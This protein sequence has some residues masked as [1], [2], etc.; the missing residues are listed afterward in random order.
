MSLKLN[1]QRWLFSTNAK[2]IAVLY[3]IFA[4][5]SAM[6]GT[7]LSAIIRLELANTGSPFLNHNT[8]AFNVVITAHAIL[9]IFFFWMPA[10]VGGFVN[11]LMPLMLGAS[12]M[13]FARLNNISFWLLVPSLIL[14]LTSALVEAGAGTG[15][16]VYFPLAGIQSHSG[17]A[18]DLAIFSLHL[19]GFSSLLGAINFITT[20]I[21][22]RTIGMK[23]ENVP[24]FA[25]AVLFTAILLLLSLPV[26]AA[27]L[28]MGIFDRNFNTSFF[29]YAGGGDAVLYQHLFLIYP[30]IILISIPGFG[31]ISHAVS[32][33]A[34]KPV[35]GVQGMIYAMG[36]I[37][38]LG[39]CVSTHHMFAVGLDSDTRAYF[40][41]A[42]MVIAVPTSIKIFSWLSKPFSKVNYSIK[43]YTNINININTNTFNKELVI[44]GS[45]LSSNI[46][47]NN[48]M[49]SVQN[50]INIPYSKLY[51]IIGILLSDGNLEIMNSKER[52]KSKVINKIVSKDINNKDIL[53][54]SRLKFKRTI[55]DIEY[56]KYVF[57][58]LM[59]YC[60]NNPKLINTKL[61]NKSLYSIELITKALPCFTILRN[62][63]YQGRVK[64]IPYDI[65]NYLSY[66]SIA[67]IIMSNGS[68]Q[69]GGGIILKL[70]GFTIKELIFLMNIFK[71]KFNIDCLLHKIN[72]KYY[73]YIK[74]D[75]VKYIYPHIEEY[76]IP[77]MKY[78]FKHKLLTKD[79]IFKVNY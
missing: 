52:N 35:F 7:G 61:K 22:M 72:N 55:I 18:V 2:D 11:Y 53:Y 46:G 39:F 30:E 10:L 74:L 5:F 32:A 50:M 58:I 76:I 69:I 43:N 73:I 24:L 29:E 54:N 79:E 78:K 57:D 75:S 9:M 4:L 13:A 49:S 34:S 66:E 67:H 65:Y 77:S 17:P 40:T 45:N 51:V 26:L 63:F 44:Y 37:G 6:I 71:I 36:S 62:K 56:F 48:L 31:I 3:F 25:W 19:S 70:K 38:L 60:I 68:F 64:I 15:W 21:N 1:I 42:T 28:T 41:S 8:Q 16:T 47:N 14:I 20:F 59:P 33:I 27:G 12:D 23:Y